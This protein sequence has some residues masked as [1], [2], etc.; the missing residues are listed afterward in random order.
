[1]IVNIKYYPVPQLTHIIRRGTCASVCNL[2]SASS[3][4]LAATSAVRNKL[5][6]YMDPD[7][8]KSVV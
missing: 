6:D 5:I 1:M 3:F 2:S 8:S 7:S 4:C